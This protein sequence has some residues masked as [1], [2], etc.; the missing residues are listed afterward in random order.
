MIFRGKKPFTT[1]DTFIAPSASVIGNVLSHDHSSVWYKAVV[2]ADSKHSI[3]IGYAS[4][5]GEGS[6]VTTLGEHAVLETG[7]P[8]HTHIGHYVTIGAGCVLK[9]CRLDDFVIVGDK[10][11]ILEGSLVEHHVI[12]EPGTVVQPYQLI[13]S[14]QKWAGNPATYVADLTLE[15]KECIQKKSDKVQALADEHLEEFLPYGFSYVHLEELEKSG[16]KA[17]Q[18]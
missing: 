16:G 3:T 15:E 8:P 12:L 2:R 6:I 11:A 14:G 1:N 10:C 4:S 5:V 17:V 18:G 9:S 13:P 7:M